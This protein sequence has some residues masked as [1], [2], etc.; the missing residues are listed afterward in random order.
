[1]IK[2]STHRHGCAKRWPTTT[3]LKASVVLAGSSS[4]TNLKRC[5][6]NYN[7][8][9][10]EGSKNLQTLSFKDHAASEMHMQATLLLKKEQSSNVHEYA[11]I[12]KHYI[13]FIWTDSQKKVCCC[14]HHCKGTLPSHKN[15]LNVWV[16]REAWG[17][18]GPK[19]TRLV[20]PLFSILLQNSVSVRLGLMLCCMPN[21]IALKQMEA[22]ILPILKTSSI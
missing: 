5:V 17:R 18:L 12:A 20:L 2:A 7:P 8:T 9:F 16:R 10:I 22:L 14:F 19:T 1:M 13:P 15:E 4:M 21:F 3:T 6:R 11:P